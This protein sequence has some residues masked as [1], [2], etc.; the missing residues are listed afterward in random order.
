LPGTVHRGREGRLLADEEIVVARRFRLADA[1]RIAHEISGN[2]QKRWMERVH[3]HTKTA[4]ACDA[5][6]S[7]V[8][9]GGVHEAERASV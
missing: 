3:Y 4:R 1:K 9:V 8:G 7:D 6:R 2:E 5:R